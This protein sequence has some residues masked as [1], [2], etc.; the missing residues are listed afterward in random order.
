MV[1]KIG[2]GLI[3]FTLVMLGLVM[4]DNTKNKR[5][6]FIAVIFAGLAMFSYLIYLILI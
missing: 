2:I 4:F 6:S 5:L 3:I 1:S